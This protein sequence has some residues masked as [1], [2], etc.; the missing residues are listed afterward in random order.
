[1]CC[2]TIGSQAEFVIGRD[3]C[4]ERFGEHSSINGRPKVIKDIAKATETLGLASDKLVVVDD[5][6]TK[7]LEAGAFST[8]CVIVPTLAGV[9]SNY[10]RATMLLD[11]IAGLQAMTT[12]TS[13]KEAIAAAVDAVSQRKSAMLLYDSYNT[14]PLHA[15]DPTR[16]TA[17]EEGT[18]YELAAPHSPAPVEAVVLAAELA[19]GRLSPRSDSHTEMVS[20]S[21]S[22]TRYRFEESKVAVILTDK[23]LKAARREAVVSHKVPG[24]GRRACLRRRRVQEARQATTSS[25][26]AVSAAASKASGLMSS[27]D[28]AVDFFL[29]LKDVEP[30]DYGSLNINTMRSGQVRPRQR[31]D[32]VAALLEYQTLDRSRS[33]NLAMTTNTGATVFHVGNSQLLFAVTFDGA[34]KREVFDLGPCSLA[35][36]RAVSLL[37]RQHGDEDLS[38]VLIVETPV[39]HEFGG[40]HRMWVEF[41]QP[42]GAPTASA[43]DVADD[44]VIENFANSLPVLERDAEIARIKGKVR[45]DSALSETARTATLK[46]IDNAVERIGVEDWGKD[47]DIGWIKHLASVVIHE[48]ARAAHRSLAMTKATVAVLTLD[49]MQ[50]LEVGP[51]WKGDWA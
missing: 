45:A 43:G 34:G 8:Q 44:L 5:E 38:A 40:N 21:T 4:K 10:D 7:C 51:Q 46:S 29:T 31:H 20:E 41:I 9:E 11:T 13:A 50:N 39:E 1:M 48:R 22:G 17:V 42:S 27:S 2:A 25:L 30:D 3:H 15:F 24:T 36:D 23:Q 47:N 28:D 26:H 14:L 49:Y 16:F 6:A 33:G 12:H 19:S 37:A 35:I 18:V 32:V